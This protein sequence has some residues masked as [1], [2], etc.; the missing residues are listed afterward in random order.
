MFAISSAT[1]GEVRL[2][3]TELRDGALTSALEANV[4]EPLKQRHADVAV[5]LAPERER[6]R[7]YYRDVCFEIHVRHADGDEFSLI[8]GGMTDWTQS[9]LSNRKERL[10]ISG[11]G[12]EVFVRLFRPGPGSARDA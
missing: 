8:D 12:S 11:L 7:N 3:V 4:L 10:L 1:V 2:G 9:L 5:R 6:G